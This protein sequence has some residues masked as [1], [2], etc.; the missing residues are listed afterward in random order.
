MKKIVTW[1]K[2]VA[3]VCLLVGCGNQNFVD[4][5]NTK[6]SNNSGASYKQQKQDGSKENIEVNWEAGRVQGD[7]DL[8]LTR[9]DK[10]TG[11]HT[12]ILEWVKK[13]TLSVFLCLGAACL[14]YVENDK[15][16]YSVDY[17]GREKMEIMSIERLEEAQRGEQYLRPFIFG[18]FAQNR[19][20]Y[21]ATE[22]GI[23]VSDE[24]GNHIRYVMNGSKTSCFWGKYH[25]RRISK[26]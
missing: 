21:F 16:V 6:N 11:V 12:C 20:L 5:D 1:I 9:A 4:T 22:E 24:N 19:D 13:K 15:K 26:R 25:G 23:F 18:M 7:G 14:Y 3:I 17:S 8:Y 10:A 2:I